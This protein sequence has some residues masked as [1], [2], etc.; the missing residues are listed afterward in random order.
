[1][2]ERLVYLRAG[3]GSI[4]LVPSLRVSVCF[5]QSLESRLFRAMNAQ[6]VVFC[7]SASSVESIHKFAKRQLGRD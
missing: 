5:G 1:M 4:P 6:L 3:S 2:V 7:L